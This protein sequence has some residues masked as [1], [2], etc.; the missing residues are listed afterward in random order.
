MIDAITPVA[1]EAAA[2]ASAPASGSAASPQASAFDVAR[3]ADAYRQSGGTAAT[4]AAEPKPG[5]SIVEA[6]SQASEGF[7]AVINVL[8]SINGRAGAIGLKAED[9]M[10]KGPNLA[11][12]DLLLLTVRSQEFMFQCTLTS[13]VANRTSDGVQQLFRQ[14][15]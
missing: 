2:A 15:S 5:V 14:Q 1:A 3:F 6:P 11:P 13:N 8:D 4:A 9:I 12:S 10:S 7:R